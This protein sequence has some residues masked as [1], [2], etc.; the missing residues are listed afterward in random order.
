MLS[1][2]SKAGISLCRRILAQSLGERNDSYQL[3]QLL[4][5][6]SL[7][8]IPANHNKYEVYANVT[9]SSKS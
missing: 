4:N 1:I 3:P 6:V 7:P 5:S 2:P 9:D 8:K